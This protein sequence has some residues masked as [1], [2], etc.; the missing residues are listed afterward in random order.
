VRVGLFETT[1]S[2]QKKEKKNNRKEVSLHLHG[3]NI[4]RQASVF[5]N[6]P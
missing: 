2:E 6:D 5:P 1:R 3:L 4:F